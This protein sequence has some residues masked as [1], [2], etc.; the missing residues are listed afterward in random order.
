MV[1]LWVNG[2]AVKGPWYNFSNYIPIL[3][4]FISHAFF[5][6]YCLHSCLQSCIRVCKRM[7]SMRLPT[8][9]ITASVSPSIFEPCGPMSF[10]RGLTSSL[11]NNYC[12]RFIELNRFVIFSSRIGLE[13]SFRAPSDIRLFVRR[14]TIK[15]NSLYIVQCW[16]CILYIH[17][18]WENACCWLWID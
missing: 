15:M 11:S 10:H 13:P 17:T 9:F 18:Y 3:L 16:S 12:N 1:K 4:L 14:I 8:N 7:K 5:I 6:I 2:L